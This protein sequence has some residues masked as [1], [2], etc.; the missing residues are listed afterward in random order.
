[1]LIVHGVELLEDVVV[2]AGPVE[3]FFWEFV[4]VAVRYAHADVIVGLKTLN[5][6][7]KNELLEVCL[8]GFVQQISDSS[9]KTEPKRKKINV[10]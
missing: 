3:F 7:P 6:A 5:A 8:S 4:L 10:R 9:L 1:M 2:R